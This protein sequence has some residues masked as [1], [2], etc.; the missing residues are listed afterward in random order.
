MRQGIKPRITR[1]HDGSGWMCLGGMHAAFG[2]TP[3]Q[4]YAK[5]AA[6]A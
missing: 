6:H 4:A 1:C 5:W 3:A 2:D